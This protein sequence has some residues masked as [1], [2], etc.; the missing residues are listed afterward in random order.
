MQ[1]FYDTVN[2][3]AK[4][5]KPTQMFL[6]GPAGGLHLA[7]QR[8]DVESVSLGQKDLRVNPDAN[9]T[10]RYETFK[11]GITAQHD[12]ESGH[13]GRATCGSSDEYASKVVP[14]IPTHLDATGVKLVSNASFNVSSKL[15]NEDSEEEGE[16]HDPG[17]ASDG[18][19]RKSGTNYFPQTTLKRLHR[20]L[21]KK[22][23]Y[24][25]DGRATL[26][27]M[28][29]QEIDIYLAGW[30]LD[31]ATKPESYQRTI[32][33]LYEQ[34]LT[35]YENKRL[36]MKARRWENSRCQ[37]L[38]RAHHIPQLL[39]QLRRSTQRVGNFL[40]HHT[41]MNWQIRG[42]S[43]ENGGFTLAES[44]MGIRLRTGSGCI[45]E[46]QEVGQSWHS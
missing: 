22:T 46:R 44:G 36:H 13:E 23:D 45:E 4:F 31:K 43:F 21:F 9:N 18:A 6:S 30:R 15:K 8:S 27:V 28:F 29:K 3:N 11:R 10:P 34:T 40:S 16:L 5:K 32:L 25:D 7:D 33:D 2:R 41:R 35:V 19:K 39:P 20:A 37:T 12:R 14:R 1:E 26:Y 17:V 38:R 24:Y 42:R